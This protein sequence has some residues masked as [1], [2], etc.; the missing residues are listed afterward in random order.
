MIRLYPQMKVHGL[1]EETDRHN[2]HSVWMNGIAEI[3]SQLCV[4]SPSA[5]PYEVGTVRGLIL[6]ESIH[7]HRGIQEL[8]LGLTAR[9]HLVW[10]QSSCS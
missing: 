7:G 6:W 3:T 2:C 1:D 4:V 10:L 8:I 5:Q 9:A